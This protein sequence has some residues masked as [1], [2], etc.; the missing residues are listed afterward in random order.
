M[1]SEK[2]VKAGGEIHD[3]TPKLD[4]S[5]PKIE[6]KK[7]EKV[8]KTEVKAE[9]SEKKTG[10]TVGIIVACLLVIG[11]IGFAVWYFALGGKNTISGERTDV[12]KIIAGETEEQV[13]NGERPEEY[14]EMLA[15]AD[16]MYGGS[17][18]KLRSTFSL[19]AYV[20]SESDLFVEN[21]DECRADIAKLKSGLSKLETN[22]YL[23]SSEGE[24]KEA[25]GAAKAKLKEVLP[26]F[27]NMTD[28]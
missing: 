12:L 8:E 22:K 17:C 24:V 2:D 19:T 18:W 10:R 4:K 7:A 3:F 16:D 23:N 28:D 1:D 26:K 6:A 11:A 21:L 9:G 27:E 13:K 14:K 15:A 25:W 5:M 20:G